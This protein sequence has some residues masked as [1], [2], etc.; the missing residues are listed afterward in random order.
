MIVCM[1]SEL[2]KTVCIDRTLSRFLLRYPELSLRTT[3]ST[4][5]K[6]DR[7]WTS[8]CCDQYISKLDDLHK[9]GFLTKPE[10]V[11]NLDETAFCTSELF[12]RVIAKKGLREVTSQFNGTDKECVTILPCGNA[13][14]QQLKLLAL[15]AGKLHL[16]SR[17][18]DTR[19]LCYHSVN[20]S[21]YMDEIHFANYVKQEVFP[22]MTENKVSDVWHS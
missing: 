10:Q 14:G 18:E 15:Y 2:K 5:R 17:L 11:W 20:T 8:E 13:A 6:K 7:E 4:N 1:L 16:Q 3:H 21:G 9:R 19:N 12:D 22:A